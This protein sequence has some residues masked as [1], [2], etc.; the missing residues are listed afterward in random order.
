MGWWGLTGHSGSSKH[1]ER[2]TIPY[3]RGDEPRPTVNLSRS[4]DSANALPLTDGVE[5]KA[6]VLAHHQTT[7]KLANLD[8]GAR[9]GANGERVARFRDGSGRS[10]GIGI[11][12]NCDC[13]GTV[14]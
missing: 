7:V 5:V 9:S 3:L 11:W 1:A 13:F 8:E 10:G 2:S 14:T 6:T 12:E 4:Q